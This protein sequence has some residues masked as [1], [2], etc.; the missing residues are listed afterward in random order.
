MRLGLPGHEGGQHGGYADGLATQGGS[1]PVDAGGRGVPLVEEQVDR[2]HHRA[3][4]SSSLGS[5][6]LFERRASG[7]EGPLGS[8][9]AGGDGRL[10][11]E[12]GAGD[13]P[14]GE[15]GDHPQGQHRAGVSGERGVAADEHQPEHVVLKVVDGELLLVTLD[16]AGGHLGVGPDLALTSAELVDRASFGRGHQ[17]GGGIVGDAGL[18]PLCERLGE[19]LLGEVFRTADVAG[20]TQQRAEKAR[21]LLS[22]HLLDGARGILHPGISIMARISTQPSQPGHVVRWASRNA[23]ALRVASATSGSS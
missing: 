18:R 12:V 3:E 19:R 17:P 10:G 8:G 1:R 2:R 16:H 14:R 23:S 15:P 5:T 6:G 20:N 7:G 22:P 11:G 9:D 13:L 21:R 4:P